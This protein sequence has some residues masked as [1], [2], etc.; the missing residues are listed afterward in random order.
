MPFPIGVAVTGVIELMKIGMEII[1]ARNNNTLT[2]AEFEAQ[3]AKM[4]STFKTNDDAWLASK[5][6]QG[7]A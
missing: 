2:Q 6:S 3:W 1:E 5:E 7:Q 4:Q